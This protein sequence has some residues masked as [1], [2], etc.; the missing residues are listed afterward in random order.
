MGKAVSEKCGVKL[1]IISTVLILISF[2][3][4]ILHAEDKEEEKKI[5]IEKTE[6]IG[7]L[8][9]PA[10]IFPV[11]WKYPK[12]QPAKTLTPER[13]FKE[14][15]FELIDMETIRQEGLWE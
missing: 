6:V 9:R 14:E 2:I 1:I 15:I 5:M 11:R 12:G 4:N 13:S 10:V 3:G 7:V 8:E